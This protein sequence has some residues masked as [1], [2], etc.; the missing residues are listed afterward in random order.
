MEHRQL[1]AAAIL[2]GGVFEMVTFIPF[3]IAHGPTSYD[4]KRDVLGWDMQGWER[5]W[6]RFRGS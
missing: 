6:E 4:L 1:A 5:L 3:T 2:V